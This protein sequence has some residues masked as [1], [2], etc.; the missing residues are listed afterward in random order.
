VGALLLAIG[1]EVE[2]I[3]TEG[4]DVGRVEKVEVPAPVKD[5]VVKVEGE[6]VIDGEG[7]KEEWVVKD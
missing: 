1:A 7:E 5:T 3:E 6:L 4:T 2:L